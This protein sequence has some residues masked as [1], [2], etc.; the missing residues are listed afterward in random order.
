MTS[1]FKID[2]QQ[3]TGQHRFAVG[4]I[5]IRKAEWILSSNE[6]AGYRGEPVKVVKISNGGWVHT[7]CGSIMDS[8]KLELYQPEVKLELT[9]EEQEIIAG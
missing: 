5:V 4:D 7:E 8:I 2:E 9:P 6:N 1:K 3:R